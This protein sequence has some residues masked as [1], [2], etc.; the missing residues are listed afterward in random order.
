MLTRTANSS[1]AKSPTLHAHV[2]ARLQR[3]L[4]NSISAWFVSGHDFSRADH[5]S[6]FVTSAG[7]SPRGVC[8][9]DFFS[10]L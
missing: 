9:S 1:G 7:F 2:T 6:I 4:K 3:L 8:F 5:S 10:S